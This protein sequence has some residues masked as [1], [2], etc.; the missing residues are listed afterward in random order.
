MTKFE[1][2]IAF[3]SL[4]AMC[5]FMSVALDVGFASLLL[6]L[7]CICL[8]LRFLL[9]VKKAYVFLGKLN[10]KP[11]RPSK[12]S[13]PYPYIPDGSPIPTSEPLLMERI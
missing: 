3:F 6:S 5:F 8:T 1:K 10:W 2:V 9:L 12:H 4:A 13:V 7:L 11:Y